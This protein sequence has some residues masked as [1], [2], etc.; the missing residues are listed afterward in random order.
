M[1][2]SIYQ[3]TNS[4]PPSKRGSENVETPPKL[5]NSHIE[6]YNPKFPAQTATV[7]GSDQ[8]Q[9]QGIL[10]EIKKKIFTRKAAGYLTWTNATSPHRLRTWLRC[11]STTESDSSRWG[12]APRTESA[13]L[14]LDY[15]KQPRWPPLTFMKIHPHNRSRGVNKQPPSH[16][17]CSS[18][19]VFVLNMQY[20]I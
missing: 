2:G 13:R 16:I 14:Q 17:L 6:A 9:M 15:N 1:E 19:F 8:Q 10:G 20:A 11:F 12:S 18:T 7:H 3:S 4:T 5:K